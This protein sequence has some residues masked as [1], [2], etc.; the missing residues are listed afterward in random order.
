MTVFLIAHG[1]DPGRWARRHGIEP[2]TVPCDGCG[3]PKTTTLPIA[4]GALRGLLAA[5]CGCGDPS[6]TYCVVGM[7]DQPKGTDTD[8]D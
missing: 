7:F 3:Q 1:V 8:A 5:R 2:F 4:R 6:D